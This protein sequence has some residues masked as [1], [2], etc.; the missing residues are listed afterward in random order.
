MAAIQL[1]DGGLFN[2]HPA[3]PD[4]LRAADWA[5]RR[6]CCIPTDSALPRLVALC[7]AAHSTPADVQGTA[8]AE[9]VARECGIPRSSLQAVLDHLAE[10]E[11]LRSWDASEEFDDL[12]W[13]LMQPL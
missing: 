13:A 5:L 9:Q 8:E 4:R 10:K 3:R 1:L 6:T 11:I 7:L 2:Q 12:C